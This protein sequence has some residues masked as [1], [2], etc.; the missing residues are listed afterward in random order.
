MNNSLYSNLPTVNY[1]LREFILKAKELDQEGGAEFFEFLLSGIAPARH[2][3]PSHQ[4][5]LDVMPNA[6]TEDHFINVSRDYDSFIGI[7][8]DLLLRGQSLSIYPVPDPKKVLSHTMHIYRY[9]EGDESLPLHRIPNFELGYWG[10]RY[11][12]YIFFP[13][14]LDSPKYKSTQGCRLTHAQKAEFYELGL[15]PAVKEI[16]S[17]DVF[18]W[19][20]SYHTENDFRSKKRSGASTYQTKLFP[21]KELYKFTG[22]LQSHLQQNDVDWADGLF[23]VHVIRGV[24]HATRHSLT[25]RGADA[26][27]EDFL[28]EAGV[29]TTVGSWYVDVA[30]EVSSD[31][32]QCLQWMTS[33][34]ASIV[35]EALQ[36]SERNAVRITSLGSQCYSKDIVSHLSHV[37]GCRIEPGS[38]AAGPF[39]VLY[40]QLYTTDKSVTY[41]PEGRHHGK[42]LEVSDAMGKDQPPKFLN[43]LQKAF[44]SASTN[45]SSNARIEV[46]VEFE[47]ATSVLLGF[48]LDIISSSLLAFERDEWWGFRSFR[49]LAI[50][51]ILERQSK[52]KS[53]FRITRDSLLLTAACVW[54]ANSLHSRPEDGPAARSLMRAT[55]PIT[56]A[57]F[58]E[59][60]PLT[61]L[62]QPSRTPRDPDNVGDGEDVGVPTTSV[63]VVP[64]G[65]I[66]WR[67]LQLLVEVPRFRAGG[68]FLTQDAVLFWFSMSIKD[69]RLKYHSPG[70]IP[71]EVV[72]KTRV[73]TNKSHRTMIYV[74]DDPENEP[75]LFN[76]AAMGH[77]IP[78][79]P[80]DDGSDIEVDPRQA[81][82]DFDVE[83]DIDAKLTNLWHQFI[84]DVITKSPNMAGDTRPSYLKLSRVERQ[85]AGEALFKERNLGQIFRA[86]QWRVG[87]VKAWNTAFT[88][89]FPP[90][91]REVKGKRQNYQGCLY[92]KIWMD[93][94]NSRGC[95]LGTAWAM[96]KAL[97]TR[98][99]SL[100]WFP[101]AQVDKL[102]STS[103]TPPGY[104]R[105]P[106]NTGG[107]AP[108]LLVVSAPDWEE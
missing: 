31:E 13:S 39:D 15:R 100:F 12:V 53:N 62:F 35:Q 48:D 56:D 24:K 106:P 70:V 98:F 65:V 74:P 26:A 95:D 64:F 78:P 57:P 9:V 90:P 23:F 22:T 28:N 55:L 47:H 63:P 19:P 66:F 107:P 81:E 105:F 85:Q 43:E 30:L 3:Q 86:C 45:T 96:H 37:A 97:K 108:Q 1:T 58:D 67:Y 82:R 8:D 102:W 52:G 32:E 71:P 87:S 6:L 79:P 83:G 46:R 16:L 11:M 103:R 72:E 69:L 40:V 17:S 60:D 92:F 88:H 5:V 34:H 99:L 44:T 54:L 73:V 20:P 41:A 38:R 94:V 75:K 27:L 77:V 7:H 49:V 33:C 89:C 50:K 93:Y 61:L 59:I 2:G 84:Q 18:D 76:L 42:A 4:V 101:S 14:L 29:D 25:A 68:P 10:H 36:I 80:V 51:E 21:D 104:T 91:E